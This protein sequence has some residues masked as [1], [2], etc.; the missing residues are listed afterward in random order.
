MIVK[1][2]TLSIIPIADKLLGT[3]A[4]EITSEVECGDIALNN[5]LALHVVELKTN[6]PKKSL[7]GLD[8]SFHQQIVELN[9]I[10]SQ[11]GAM[12]MPTGMHPFFVPDKN[13]AL[14][15]HG[16]R[17]IYETYN[18][19]F[20][21]DGHGWSNLQSVHINLP[22]A[23]NDEF[24]KLHSAIR[25]VLPL[26]PALA[27]ST[28]FSEG[29]L[30]AVLDTRLFH[31][32]KNQALLPQ[33]SGDIIPEF[34]G[35][36]Q[37]YHEKILNPMYA[38]IH[39][40]D[41][42]KILQYEWLNSRGAIARFERDAI[43]I[44]VTDIQE[45]PKMDFAVISAIVAA[46]ELCLENSATAGEAIDTKQLK[47]IYD[48][49]IKNGLDTTVNNTAYL[50]QLGIAATKSTLRE[51]WQLLLARS[52]NQAIKHYQKQIEFILK[53]GCLAQRMKQKYLIDP[54]SNT[55]RDIFNNLSH[56][57]AENGVFD[58]C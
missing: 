10:L 47:Q 24:V 58:G 52:N 28:P 46:I 16:D 41:P 34:V 32:E 4:G 22:F 20:N 31:Y 56:A 36:M 13:I 27:A 9:H 5:E 25:L 30:S 1:Q 23:N 43:E 42:E 3:V 37:E 45:S 51:I 26:I 33:I 2:D 55:I 7:T 57:L 39:E 15:P 50:R 8:Q 21:C 48:N 29:K 17:I 11:D 14:W 54:S 44:R 12:L 49:A 40:Y 53:N 18:R 6:G 38:A 35:S 19:I